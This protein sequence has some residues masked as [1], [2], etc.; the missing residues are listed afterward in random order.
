MLD[1]LLATLG[2]TVVVA[3]GLTALAGLTIVPFVSALQLAGGDPQRALSPGRVGAFAVTGVLLGLA[4]VAGILVAGA[5][6]FLTLP[7]LAL[8]WV[9]PAALRLLGS[10]SLAG[11]AGRH[12]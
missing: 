5:P 12:E 9:V 6:V 4:S 11:A 7:A 3:V 1:L 8:T 10:P 2:L